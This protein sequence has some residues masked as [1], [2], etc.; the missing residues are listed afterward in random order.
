[1]EHVNVSI[2]FIVFQVSPGVMPRPCIG[3]VGRKPADVSVAARR[4]TGGTSSRK[5]NGVF[6]LENQDL[7]AFQV[8]F[9]SLS[10]SRINTSPTTTAITATSLLFQEL[11]RNSKRCSLCGIASGATGGPRTSARSSCQRQELVFIGGRDM[12]EED[13]ASRLVKA[14]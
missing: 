6:D 2:K 1:M 8:I 12:D 3:I 7:F 9:C 5:N 10:K 14:C 13:I 11:R 4:P